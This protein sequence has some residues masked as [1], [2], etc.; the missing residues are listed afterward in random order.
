[1]HDIRRER[2]GD[3]LDEAARDMARL[4][5]GSSSRVWA[6]A[7]ADALHSVR[8]ELGRTRRDYFT[9]DDAER[10]SRVAYPELA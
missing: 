8:K 6:G 1:M 10:V 9:R 5:V 2:W 7:Y 3:K 4:P